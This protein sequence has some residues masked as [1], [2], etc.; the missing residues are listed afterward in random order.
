VKLKKTQRNIR[1]KKQ[2]KREQELF[3]S[4]ALSLPSLE[5]CSLALSLGLPDSV[6]SRPSGQASKRDA[7]MSTEVAV[8]S[9]FAPVGFA[10]DSS[11]AEADRSSEV[12]PAQGDAGTGADDTPPPMCEIPGQGFLASFFGGAAAEPEPELPKELAT[13]GQW[14]VEPKEAVLARA[15]ELGLSA[16]AYDADDVLFTP[17]GKQIG[18]TQLGQVVFYYAKAKAMA[19]ECAVVGSGLATHKC[20][21]LRCTECVATAAE[22][23][24]HA[25]TDDAPWGVRLNVK[26]ALWQGRNA[27]A[28]WEASSDAPIA[29]DI[30]CSAHPALQKMYELYAAAVKD[31]L[32]PVGPAWDWLL[33]RPKERKFSHWSRQPLREEDKHMWFCLERTDFVAKD[34]HNIT[35]D[36]RMSYVFGKV[37]HTTAA[38]DSSAS[39]SRASQVGDAFRSSAFAGD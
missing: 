17:T 29:W 9:D 22:S 30:P 3:V 15:A 24:T 10:G 39:A 12:E 31:E 28:A 37:R 38:H 33:D 4:L 36:G 25:C 34:H 5:A 2:R 23:G 21:E 35:F 8:A 20:T 11:A 1:G 27:Q 13:D 7:Q 16:E 18:R 26:A 6:L 14:E 19:E 32:Q